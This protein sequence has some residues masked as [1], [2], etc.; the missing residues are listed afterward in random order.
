MTILTAGQQEIK[1][2]ILLPA[3]SIALLMSLT[4]T[5]VLA[6]QGSVPTPPPASTVVDNNNKPETTPGSAPNA[7]KETSAGDSAPPLKAVPSKGGEGAPAIATRAKAANTITITKVSDSMPTDP[8]FRHYFVPVMKCEKYDYMREQGWDIQ[9]IVTG[10][11]VGQDIVRKQLAEKGLFFQGMSLSTFAWNTLN[12]PVARRDQSSVGDR[13]YYAGDHEWQMIYSFPENSLLKN[14]QIVSSA[15]FNA[16]TMNLLGGAHALRMN[17]LSYHQYFFN[18]RFAIKG[19]YV[20]SD[21]DWMNNF[22]AGNMLTGVM[23]MKGVIPYEVGMTHLPVGSPGF[24][25]RVVPIKHTY[26]KLGIQQSEV[27]K[28]SQ[29]DEIEHVAI[30]AT[31]FKIHLPNAHALYLSEVG[32]KREAAPGVKDVYIRSGGEYNFSRFWNFDKI[33]FPALVAGEVPGVTQDTI[34][35]GNYATWF[36][37]DYQLLQ[38][39]P[40]LAYRGVYAGT[41]IMNSPSRPN[42]YQSYYEARLYAVGIIPHRY[43]DIMAFQF[44]NTQFSTAVLNGYKAITQAETY[45]PATATMVTPKQYGASTSGI[46]YYTYRVFSGVYFQTG[47]SYNKHPGPFYL[48]TNPTKMQ[49]GLKDTLTINVGFSMLF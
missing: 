9:S 22:L 37:A 47:L 8:T 33:T 4:A 23:G 24:N 14:A 44:T 12:P 30:D 20:T 11:T 3:I 21:L 43:F 35:K 27:I 2:A 42:L 10:D 48:G 19:G 31:G 15:T 1:K 25:I 32:Y 5:L 17:K 18:E 41:S 38:T 46:A 49:Q 39:D 7:P 45:N 40:H 34:R 16:N 6:Q 29:A 13:A 36:L 26:I 28:N